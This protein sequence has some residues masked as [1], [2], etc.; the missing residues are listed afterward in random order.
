[1]KEKG[2]VFT[3]LALEIIRQIPGVGWCKCA[4]FTGERL[5]GWVSENYLAMARISRW[6]FTTLESVVTDYQYDPSD[7]PYERWTRKQCIQWMKIYGVRVADVMSRSDLKL[8]NKAFEEM[9]K[10]AKE[11]KPMSRCGVATLRIIVA[12]MMKQQG[13]NQLVLVAE[14]IATV[15]EVLN[16][17]TCCQVMVATAMAKKSSDRHVKELDRMVK[18]FLTTYGKFEEKMRLQSGGDK[19]KKKPDWVSQYNFLSL[20]QYMPTILGN[21]NSAAWWKRSSK[22]LFRRP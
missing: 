18:I 10:L 9:K 6:F 11:K 14:R 7:E 4:P 1:M 15:R 8:N 20:L 12:E 5:G 22:E 2:T 19:A 13:A 3:N 21:Q 17:V 16:V